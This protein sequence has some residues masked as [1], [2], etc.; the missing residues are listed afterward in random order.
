[1]KSQVERDLFN[2]TE[3]EKVPRWHH[4]VVCISKTRINFIIYTETE[5]SSN[6]KMRWFL[7][8]VRLIQD[9]TSD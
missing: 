6:V 7:N 3:Y 5:L 8:G 4:S 1:M 9:W 2:D